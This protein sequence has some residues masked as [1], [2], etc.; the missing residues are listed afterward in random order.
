MAPKISTPK[1]FLTTSASKDARVGIAKEGVWEDYQPYL[2]YRRFTMAENNIINYTYD[3]NG[4]GKRDPS[5]GNPT[6]Y[7]RF[8]GLNWTLDF[9]LGNLMAGANYTINNNLTESIPWA[10]G[11]IILPKVDGHLWQPSTPGVIIRTRFANATHE[12]LDIRINAPGKVAG[13]PTTTKINLAP[14]LI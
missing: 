14:Q 8:G 3:F 7:H 6:E 1:I 11:A 4:D 5:Y 12:F 2:G 10:R 13:I 9:D